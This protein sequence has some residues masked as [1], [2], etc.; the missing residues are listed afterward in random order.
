MKM[1]LSG[2]I[3]VLVSK[4]LS[5]SLSRVKACPLEQDLKCGQHQ[6]LFYVLV[7]LF[8]TP[9]IG[10]FGE[11]CYKLRQGKRERERETQKERV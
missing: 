10:H 2:K 1:K 7:C 9:L 8:T 4:S 11:A 3:S 5:L 6:K